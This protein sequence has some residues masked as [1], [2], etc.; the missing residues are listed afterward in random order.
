M[1][2]DLTTQPASRGLPFSASPGRSETSDEVKQDDI[3]IK[4]S[5][6]ISLSSDTSARNDEIVITDAEDRAVRRKL[7]M[8]VMPILFLGFYVFQASSLQSLVLTENS[9]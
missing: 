7:D 2:V 6:A 3:S 8:V 4:E 5:G 1:S 9:H